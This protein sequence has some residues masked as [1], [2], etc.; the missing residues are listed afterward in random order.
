MAA[1]GNHREGQRITAVSAGVLPLTT[2]RTCSHRVD[3]EAN[4]WRCLEFRSARD[5]PHQ[6]HYLNPTILLGAVELLILRSQLEG[7][8][9]GL[10]IRANI[11]ANSGELT[12]DHFSHRAPQSTRSRYP[13]IPASLPGAILQT[14]LSRS[15]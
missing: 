3:A 7:S 12:V 6:G 4:R 10:H 2:N 14:S 1:D 8:Q 13:P 5:G 11:S 15:P 9:S